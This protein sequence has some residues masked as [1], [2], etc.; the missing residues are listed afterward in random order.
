M[1][2]LSLF[3]LILMAAA[4]CTQAPPPA[5]APEPAPVVETTPPPPP[6]PPPDPE[7]FRATVPAPA[8]PRP[9]KFPDV[10]RFTLDNG[11][12]VLVATTTSAPLVTV[13]A[14]V[15]SG[16]AHDPA[17]HAGLA[18]LTAQ[19]VD[20]GAGNRTA[21]QIAE[22]LGTLGASLFTG[23]DYDASF[24]NLDILGSQLSQGF[25]IFADVVRRP[26]FAKADFDREKKDR[27]T[28]LLQQKDQPTIIAGNQFARF[29]YGSAPY[30]RPLSGTE[31]TAKQITQKDVRDFY[32]RHWVPN[33]TSL[34]ITG[35]VD[36][37]T[38]RL[39]AQQY[40]GNWRRGKDVPEINVVAPAV[41]RS[42]IHL[43]D[44]P[45]AVQS[46]IR[47]G[48]VGVP[49]GTDDYFALV[50]MNSIL[51]GQFTSRL[52][53]NLREKHGYTYGA[54][55]TFA[56][57]RQAGPFTASTAVRNAVT[58]ESVRE[59]ISELK[60]LG[61]G[62]ITD[63][64]LMFAK[65]YLMGVFP[66][67]VQTAAELAQ[68]I[69]ELE[70]YN[71]PEDYFDRYRERIAAVSKDDIVAAAREY[72]NPEKLVVVVVGKAEEVRQPLEALGMPITVHQIE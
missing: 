16:G 11:M 72:I 25:P 71:L 24:V 9:Y 38:A 41:E 26:K 5:P 31:A 39:L 67:T 30:G 60:R 58:S 61:S 17:S 47:V 12:R 43:I 37:V 3:L 52:N 22:E 64:E 66:A 33:N 48:H 10:E 68:R 34:I 32:A 57:R 7:A 14:V 28:T 46:E 4:S 56:F 63:T 69:Q 40:F 49:R 2:R 27:L 6:P 20:E 50:T 44:R 19:L 36:I 42:Q 62:D 21:I 70:L 55:S 35:N 15:R 54:R 51:G 1:K 59:T 29:V 18:S 13:R 65:N 23:A 8:S 53:L 45:A